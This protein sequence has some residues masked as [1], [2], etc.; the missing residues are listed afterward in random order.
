MFDIRSLSRQ[1]PVNK[2]WRSLP[3]V[4]QLLPNLSHDRATGAIAKGHARN[5]LT[6]AFL[7]TLAMMCDMLAITGWLKVAPEVSF[8]L[9]W[10]FVSSE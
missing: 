1:N 5:V 10:T 8:L 3:V 6:S 7:M 4:V 2:V 9:F